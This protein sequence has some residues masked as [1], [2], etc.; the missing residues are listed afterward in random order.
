[1]FCVF[2]IPFSLESV[3]VKLLNLPLLG[4]LIYFPASGC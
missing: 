1:M 3:I 2:Q 4:Y